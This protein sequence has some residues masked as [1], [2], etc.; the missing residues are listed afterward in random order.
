M[1]LAIPVL[2]HPCLTPLANLENGAVPLG[3]KGI[4]DFGVVPIYAKHSARL[5]HGY[6][7]GLSQQTCEYRWQCELIELRDGGPIQKELTLKSQCLSSK[8]KGSQTT[9]LGVT[10]IAHKTGSY[11]GQPTTSN[12]AARGRGFRVWD[13]PGLAESTQKLCDIREDSR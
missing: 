1:R 5:Y 10:K 7:N 6:V 4:R 3:D 9:V 13:S 8:P 2:D 12:V 11:M